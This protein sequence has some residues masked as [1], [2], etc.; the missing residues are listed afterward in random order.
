VEGLPAGEGTITAEL[1]GFNPFRKEGVVLESGKAKRIDIRLELPGKSAS[2]TVESEPGNFLIE[3]PEIAFVHAEDKSGLLSHESMVAVGGGPSVAQKIYV[4]GFEDTLL[5]V[6]VDGAQQAGELY[7]H[8]G[9]VQIEPEFL[10]SI[11]LEAG[12]GPATSGP[13]MLASPPAIL[14]AADRGAAPLTLAEII[15]RVA[16]D[17]PRH[18]SIA[19]H[20]PS[21]SGP[22]GP[23]SVV[24]FERAPFATRG[25]LQLQLDPH[26]GAVLSA[27]GWDS[28][29]AGTRARILIRFLHT[30]E[31]LGLPGR[32]LAVTATA[33]SLLL[34]YTGFAL[35]WR[36]PRIV[37]SR[38]RRLRD[39]CR[40]RSRLQLDNPF[41]R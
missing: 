32:I 2:V 6:T 9:R 40:I 28:R 25:R 10:K 23:V 5:N 26:S 14:P 1:P 15:R 21:R 36:R 17:H 39:T 31:A 38:L 13:G 19:V 11:E 22:S 20:I 12:A 41:R 7:H 4:R 18:E 24:V 29:S 34:V 37:E 33:L 8:Q 30:G 35:S 16:A 3:A 27:L